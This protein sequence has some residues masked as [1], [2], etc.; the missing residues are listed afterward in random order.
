[1]GETHPFDEGLA[2]ERQGADLVRGR[3]TA[4]WRNFIGPF[5]GLTAAQAMQAILLHPERLGDPVAF[6]VNFAAAIA[7]G[8][9]DVI[10]QPVRTN[11]STQHW[12]VSIR[13]GD[14]VML[15]GT[16]MTAV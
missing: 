16:A 1:M 15:L 9:F 14:A 10:A 2:L 6:T 8:E 4:P 3:T 7:D 13:Q 12:T 5:G 11:R